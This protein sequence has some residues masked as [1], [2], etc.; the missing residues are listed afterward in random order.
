MF[1]LR[2]M[3][4]S[5]GNLRMAV[6]AL[7]SILYLKTNWSHP[8]KLSAVCL[9]SRSA[10]CV[11]YACVLHIWVGS[12]FSLI[13]QGY[14]VI[15][16]LNKIDIKLSHKLYLVIFNDGV[17]FRLKFAGQIANSL[18]VFF[19]HINPSKWFTNCIHQVCPA[20]LINGFQFFAPA[21]ISLSLSV[22]HSSLFNHL[23]LLF[24]CIFDIF[25]FRLSSIF[26]SISSV[27]YGFFDSLF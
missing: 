9:L 4:L 7:V 2:S 25:H 3:L 24:L 11:L 18:F 20:S 21:T 22:Y 12:P 27:T 16:F 1:W 10:L 17:M 6:A 15:N 19:R 26:S 13:I 8:M 23:M 5:P 14:F